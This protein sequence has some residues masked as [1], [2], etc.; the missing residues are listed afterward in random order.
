LTSFIKLLAK[1]GQIDEKKISLHSKK[2]A[3]LLPK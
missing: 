3:M 2:A 1:K